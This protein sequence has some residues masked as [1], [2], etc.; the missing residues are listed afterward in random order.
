MIARLCAALERAYRPGEWWRA[1]VWEPR[2]DPRI[3]VREHEPIGNARLR[4]AEIQQPWLREAI[5][6]YFARALE[7]GVLAWTSLPGY[8]TYLGSYFSEFLL[9]AGIDHPRLVEDESELRGVALS[10]LSHLRG[11]R[12]RRG[13]GPLSPVSVGLSQTA[14]QGFY[15]FMADHRHEAA[16][17]LDEPCWT[18][19]SDAHARLW[20]AGE[21][22]LDWRA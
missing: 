4:F 10:F 13:G 12:S 5:K 15:L 8:R 3:P 14:V 11:G 1:D 22:V 19:L 21:F 2:R 7:Q 9:R 16:K 6:W 18:E 20:R 17:A